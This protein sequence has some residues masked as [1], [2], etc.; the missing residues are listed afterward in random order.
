[1]VFMASYYRGMFPAKE[2][3]L[4][5]HDLWQKQDARVVEIIDDAVPT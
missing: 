5:G 3:H 2:R 1:M 4:S